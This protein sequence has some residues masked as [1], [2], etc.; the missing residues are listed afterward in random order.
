MGE[1]RCF[2][3]R[4]NSP[5]VSDDDCNTNEICDDSTGHCSVVRCDE[6]GMCPMWRWKPV[7]GT[8]GC[9]Y[10]PCPR[11]SVIPGVCAFDKWCVEC[12]VDGD[13]D[14]G[15]FCSLGAR[16]LEY[17]QC[18]VTCRNTTEICIDGK[19]QISCESDVDCLSG[20]GV[21]QVEGYCFFVRCNPDGTCPDGWALGTME[22]VPETLACVKLP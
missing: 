7:P 4:C 5:C 9:Q 22:T 12:I 6:D 3:Q 15:Q 13:C 10:D 11:G 19:C 17:P 8:L 21:C 14:D 2:E 20:A 16:C 1:S 18:E